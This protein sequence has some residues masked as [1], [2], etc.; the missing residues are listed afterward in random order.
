MRSWHPVH[1]FRLAQ[2]DAQRH[3]GCDPLRH[4]NH[5]RMHSAVLDRPP[6]S[7]AS[8]PALHFISDQQ[9]PVLVANLPQL[10]QEDRRRWYVTAFALHWLDENCRNFLGRNR[11][12]ENFIF[13]KSRARQRVLLALAVDVGKKNVRHSRHQRREA[14]AL[15]RLGRG[16]RQ[17]SHGSPME[18]AKKR[19][20]LLPACV[21]ARQLER[22]LNRL[23]TRVPVVNAMRPRHRRNFRQPL[24]QRDQ[25]FIIKIRARH[26]DQFARLL[27]N[28]SNHV[29]MAMAGGSDSDAGRKI[30]K[31]VAIH[32]GDEDSA[33]LLCDKRIRAG[34]RRRNVTLIAFQNTLGVRS[35]QCGLNLRS[36]GLLLIDR[37]VNYGR[38]LGCHGILLKAVVG[39]T[40]LVVGLTRSQ[41]TE[42]CRRNRG[43]TRISRCRKG[44]DA[45]AKAAPPNTAAGTRACATS[46]RASASWHCGA[47]YGYCNPTL[48][49]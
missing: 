39:L 2:R 13:N 17:R 30:E 25:A 20:H 1:N 26:V 27:L 29:G 32:I 42:A 23:R 44:W 47:A 35:R 31:L 22:A 6:L 8:C 11:S 24:G 12:L 9:D 16:Q 45:N 3:A 7:A 33:S 5:V 19:D 36:R 38:I 18:G 46:R 21:I 41:R 43:G 40:S 37:R 28:G 10:L 14:A 34:I 15:L 4:A 48:P 49:K